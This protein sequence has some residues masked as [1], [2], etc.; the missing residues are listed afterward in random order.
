M[1][2]GVRG[3]GESF[4]YSI[5]KSYFFLSSAKIS[6]KRTIFSGVGGVVFSASSSSF[7]R[8]EERAFSMQKITNAS[9]RKLITAVRKAP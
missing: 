6:L 3:V 7:L 1:P 8:M 5:I 9:K 4:P 2:S